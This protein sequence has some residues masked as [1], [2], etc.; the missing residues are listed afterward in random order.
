MPEQVICHA[1]PSRSFL[2]RS[3]TRMYA[4]HRKKYGTAP[5]QSSRRARELGAEPK[6]FSAPPLAH[7]MSWLGVTRFGLTLLDLTWLGSPER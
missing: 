2:T 3:F 5:L 6:A 1:Y 7:R 4:V